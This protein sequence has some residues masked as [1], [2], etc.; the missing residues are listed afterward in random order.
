MGRGRIF[1]TLTIWF[2]MNG[3][4]VR[5]ILDSGGNEVFYSNIQFLRSIVM[6]V[7]TMTASVI[8]LLTL[9]VKTQEHQVQQIVDDMSEDFFNEG[10]HIDLVEKTNSNHHNNCCF[11][12]CLWAI[13][14]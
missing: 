5:L 9:V 10:L 3:M 2:I 14:M 12:W 13:L 4:L 11:D 6:A 7:M 1:M 8:L